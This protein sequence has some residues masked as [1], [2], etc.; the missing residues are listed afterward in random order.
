MSVSGMRCEHAEVRITTVVLL[1]ALS[2]PFVV[3]DYVTTAWLI[4][5]NVYNESNPIVASL[6]S[7]FGH[8]G[9]LLAKVM[10][11][12]IIGG[13]AYLVDLKFHGRLNKFRP[14]NIHDCSYWLAV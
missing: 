10:A 11:F 3:G 1:V 9:L 13:A 6:Y 2:I 14:F 5:E 12:L 4:Y 7:D 8:S